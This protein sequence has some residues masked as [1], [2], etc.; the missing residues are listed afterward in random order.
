MQPKN[1]I[2]DSST[3][4]CYHCGEQ[5]NDSAILF[6]QKTF[7]CNG[8]KSVFEILKNN[9]LC[10]YYT[11]NNNPGNN[12]KN[13]YRKNKFAF[14]DLKEIS[15][16]FILQRNEYHAAVLF[17]IPQ[18][19]CSSCM[20]LLESLNK[21]NDGIIYS[22]VNFTNK[23]LYIQFK[24][25]K[26][27][28]R[29]I[30]ELI[31]SL[32]YEPDLKSAEKK[33]AIDK[34][35]K[36]RTLKIGIAGFAFANIMMFSL[37][38]Y[39]SFGSELSGII[40]KFFMA[41]S[42]ILSLPVLFFCASEFFINAWKGL[43]HKIIN[44]DAPVALA[45]AITFLRSIYE[46]YIGNG[47]GYLDSMSGIVFF[48]LIGRWLQD[49]TYHTIQ[50]DRN[51]KTF[52]PIA[53]EKSNGNTIVQVP[54]E[55]LQKGD[56]I[57]IYNEEIIPVDSIL[58]S[59]SANLDYSFISGESVPVNVKKGDKIFAGAKQK[60][61]SI[62]IKVEKPV[63][64]SYLNQLWNQY[65][66]KSIEQE[67]ETIYDL[68]A[69]YFSIAVL[70]IGAV[71]FA[72]W[73]YMDSMEKALNAITT[74]LIVAC[75]CA[76]LLSR[77]FTNGNI[78]RVLGLN[79]MYIKN[80]KVLN[81][82]NNVNHIIFDKT[83]TLTQSNNLNVIYEGRN[84]N[85]LESILKSV[86]EGSN[87]PLSKAIVNYFRKYPSIKIENFKETPGKGIESWINEIYIKAGNNK[88]TGIDENNIKP[89][90]YLII[91]GQYIGKFVI[92]NIYRKNIFDTLKKLKE[93]KYKLSILSGDN[94]AENERLKKFISSDGALRFNQF[95]GDKLNF[96]NHSKHNGDN[97]MMVGD[98]INDSAALLTSNVGVAITE[99]TNNFSPACDVILTA[100]NTGRF[101]ELINFIKGG[102]KIIIAT[103]IISAIYNIIGLIFSIQGILSPVIAA[104]LMPSSSITI[105]L[106]TFGLTQYIANQLNLKR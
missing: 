94:D 90:V 7:C 18:I 8:C 13:V 27:S 22:R 44:I 86:F 9:E 39:L 65:K 70:I 1:K 66:P 46:M 82:I 45:V 67:K 29:E 43:K 104:I 52:F 69:R 31:T 63:S 57:K 92:E 49:K 102:R 50:F 5:C 103:F 62:F 58:I 40:P 68:I 77:D 26:I 98:G 20:W 15:E 84:I 97:V 24:E 21:L 32:G 3:S 28:F 83:G 30:V 25:E 76:L 73:I 2:T 38:D 55:N 93:R 34:L 81:D 61:G 106:M 79:G 37:P 17:Q 48:M 96:I 87:H 47:N 35:Q 85:G 16:K 105:I 71:S 56:V 12:Q 75:P 36:R 80:T 33:E 6:E 88:F 99:N 60:D 95:P 41:L 10:D 23:E 53:V 4:V 91:D 64:Q 42:I 54:V 89:T 14:L 11:L 100:E 78:L 59:A 74:V 101:N 19:H 72:F 51:F